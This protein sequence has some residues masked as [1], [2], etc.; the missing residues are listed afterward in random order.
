[1]NFLV[2]LAALFGLEA[3]AL[4]QRAKG[5]LVLLL[6]VGTLALVGFVFLLIAAYAALYPRFGAVWSPLILAGIA[7]AFALVILLATRIGEHIRRRRLAERRR[8]SETTALVT[9]A[10]VTALPVLLKSPALRSLALPLALAG[11]W[12]VYSR[13]TG[14]RRP[15]DDA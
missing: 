1:M 4:V 7:F 8:S 10:A 11:A 13:S 12:M 9:S 15:D 2:P 3:D 14:T 6:A 5:Q